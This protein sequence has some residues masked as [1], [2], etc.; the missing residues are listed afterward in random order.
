MANLVAI[1]NLGPFPAGSNWQLL[2]QCGRQWEFPRTGIIACAFCGLH[3]GRHSTHW[4][5]VVDTKALLRT[6]FD[7]ISRMDALGDNERHW[8]RGQVVEQITCCV[9]FEK[10]DLNVIF[11]KFIVS[12]APAPT[13]VSTEFQA[14]MAKQEAQDEHMWHLKVQLQVCS[15]AAAQPASEPP[16]LTWV[17]VVAL[18][19]RGR[20]PQWLWRVLRLMYVTIRDEALL[21]DKATCTE[22]WKESNAK[23]SLS[24]SQ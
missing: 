8:A 18:V 24:I 4:Q 9:L 2:G 20:M 21:D 17:P 3:D 6:K 22:E 23:V 12:V 16:A 7:V 5:L 1:H 11:G 19:E 13:N 10:C 15:W 14:L